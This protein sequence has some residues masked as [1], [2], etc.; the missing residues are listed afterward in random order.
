MRNYRIFF[1][2]CLVEP[3][4]VKKLA[5]VLNVLASEKQKAQKV[6]FYVQIKGPIPYNLDWLNMSDC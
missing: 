1:I 3:D 4:E 2:W 6:S 5:S